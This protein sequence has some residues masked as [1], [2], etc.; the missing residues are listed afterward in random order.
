MSTVIP[1]PEL[2]SPFVRLVAENV[3]VECGRADWVQADVARALGVSRQT[4]SV[5][6]RGRV[7]WQLEDLE[8][9]AGA[10]GIPVARFFARSEGFEPPTF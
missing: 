6:W 3:R 10:M 8:K 5:R 1:L 4:V 7:Q 2:P 9:L